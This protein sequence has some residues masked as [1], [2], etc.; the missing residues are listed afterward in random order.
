MVNNDSVVLE[1]RLSNL[2]FN[3][4]SNFITI[5]NLNI[6]G[7]FNPDLSADYLSA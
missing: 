5:Q 1:A 6:Q 4:I 3:F 2:C 7:N